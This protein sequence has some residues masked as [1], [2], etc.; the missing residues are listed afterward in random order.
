MIGGLQGLQQVVS[1][2]SADPHVPNIH[3]LIAAA[4]AKFG[5]LN[6]VPFDQVI[7][8]V[9]AYHPRRRHNPR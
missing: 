3:G 6:A 7:K 4:Q 1:S 5:G 8:G 2:E 9:A